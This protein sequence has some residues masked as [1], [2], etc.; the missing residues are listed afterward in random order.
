[1]L[2]RGVQTAEHSYTD[3]YR[4]CPPPPSPGSLALVTSEYL[5]FPVFFR[6]ENA[7]ASD[8]V[9]KFLYDDEYQHISA[10]VQASM[11]DKSYKV[12]VLYF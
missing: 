10:V 3:R 12:E 1:M 2:K 8:H 5:Y 11:R 9:L 4:E 7:V 6:S